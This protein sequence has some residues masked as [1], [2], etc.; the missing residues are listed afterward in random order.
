MDVGKDILS[1]AAV[2]YTCA[3][4]PSSMYATLMKV[5]WPKERKKQDMKEDQLKRGRE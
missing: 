2:R 5:V 1:G 3:D 4:N